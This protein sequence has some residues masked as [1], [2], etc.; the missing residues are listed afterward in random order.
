MKA[1]N[2]ITSSGYIPQKQS[3]QKWIESQKHL[4]NFQNAKNLRIKNEKEAIIFGDEEAQK[5]MAKY[6]K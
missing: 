1:N 4:L 3:K 5:I 2:T 6:Y